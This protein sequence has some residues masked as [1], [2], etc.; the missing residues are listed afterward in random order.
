MVDTFWDELK[1]LQEQRLIRALDYQ[2]A[3]FLAVQG[4]CKSQ[5]LLGA[6]VSAQLMQGNVCLP[7]AQLLA[8]GG[9]APEIKALLAG[10]MEAVPQPDGHILG[11]GSGPDGDGAVTPLVLDAGRYYLYRYWRFERDVSE[12]LCLRAGPVAQDLLALK[13]TIREL[14][15]PQDGEIDW[16]K[17]AAAVAVQRRFAVISGGPGTGKTTTVIKLLA[18]YIHQMMEEGRA[19][20][21]RLAA[22]TG[23]AAARLSES[24]SGAR[25][26]LGLPDAVDTL[27]PEDA[28]TLHRLLGVIP[29][30]HRFRHNRENPLHLDLL[31]VDEASMVD[32]PMM[33]RLLEALP[34][35]ARLV[36]IGDRDQLASVEAGSVLG[37]ICSWP[38]EPGYSAAQA[39]RLAPLCD[40][41][42]E[43]LQ[44]DYSAAIADSVAQLRKS[45]R[46]HENSGIGYLARAVNAGEPFAVNQVLHRGWSDIAFNALDKASYEKLIG[47]CVDG[48]SAYLKAMQQGS[49]PAVV[50][51]LF[52]EIQ[53]LC[54]LREGPFGVAG[55]NESIRKGLAR[56]GLVSSEG[57]WF[58]GRPVIV[59]RN[60]PALELYNGDV[61]IALPDDEGA[62][63]VWFEQA[64]EVRPVL[65]SRLPDHETVFAMT[66]H[67]SQGS[68]FR[69][70]LLVLPPG[71]NPLLTRE[72]LYTGITRAKE[73]F[74]LYATLPSLRL[75]VQRRTERVG[76]LRERLWERG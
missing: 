38:G 70:T 49:S 41:P 15:P 14:F 76:G 71:D 8:S 18:L 30:S 7:A 29:N 23:K 25:Q 33:A 21:I 75:S 26:K 55:L 34:H 58:S 64:G 69:H 24:I 37:D 56:R 44:Q 32:L 3:R 65:P 52:S 50:L 13:P 17:V 73:Q 72:L 45:Y 10:W 12:E 28:S 22:P 11:D 35:S 40:L 60:E 6:L 39:A 31:V 27:I 2:F 19:P 20:L 74:D 59:T 36:L 9:L 54:A 61:G 68:E 43:A 51:A 47:S 66:V 53:L 67:K 48:Y 63:K 62:L 42:V 46:F 5:A 4:A 57:Q 1:Q 16:Q